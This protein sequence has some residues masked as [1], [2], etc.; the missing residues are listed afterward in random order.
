MTVVAYCENSVQYVSPDGF[1]CIQTAYDVP[2]GPLIGWGGGNPLPIPY[3]LDAF[4][5]SL[6]T[7][8]ASNPRRLW[9]LDSDPPLRISGY[10]TDIN[11]QEHDLKAVVV[12]KRIHVV[13][14][15]LTA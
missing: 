1:F 11:C 3:P 12:V 7:P 9:R 5:V 10:A 4:G 2:P 14:E 6:S 13:V 8:S 15:S